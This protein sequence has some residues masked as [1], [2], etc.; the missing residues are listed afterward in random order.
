MSNERKNW[1]ALVVLSLGCFTFLACV[2][3]TM[4]KLATDLSP[5]SEGLRIAYRLGM[6]YGGLLVLIWVL[7][8]L[9]I[10]MFVRAG[11]KT[12]PSSPAVPARDLSPA[13]EQRRCSVRAAWK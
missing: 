13:V 3:R 2:Y 11:T 4:L 12:H 6:A 10:G 9:C 5:T 1:I 7:L 8:A